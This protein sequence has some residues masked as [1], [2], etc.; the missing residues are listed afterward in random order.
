VSNIGCRLSWFT[1][2][3]H[4]LRVDESESVN[5]DFSFDGLYGIDDDGNG[6]GIEGFK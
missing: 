5:D 2:R 1:T 4:G 6:S 3:N